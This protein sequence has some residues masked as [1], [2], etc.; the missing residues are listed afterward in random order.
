VKIHLVTPR[1]PPSFW[2]YD[3]ILPTLGKRCIFPNLSMPT[4]AGLTPPEHEVT[5]CDENVR[6][7]DFDVDAD[8]IGITGYIIHAP[9]IRELAREFRR[10]GHRVVIGGPFATLCPERVRELC[11]VLFI[12]E[13]EET[14]PEFLADLERGRFRSEYREAG[15]PDLS[16]AP[17]PRFDLLDVDRYHALTI[18]FG[19]GCPFRCEFCDIIV[20][21]GRRPRTKT[22]EQVLAEIAACH[23]LGANQVFIVDDNF[24]GDRN[25]AKAVLR[26]IA[27]WSEAHGHPIAFNTEVSL[28]VAS[29]PELL[30]LLRRARFT[31]VFVGIESP[32]VASLEE[33]R[34]TQNT[35]GDLLESVRRIQAFGIQVQAGMIVGFDHDDPTIFEEQ[36]RFVQEAAIPVSMT[37]ML[38][39]LPGTPLHQRV[40]R[41]GRLLAESTGDQFVFSNIVPRSMTREELYRGYR[42]LLRR[43]Y[44]YD[45]YRERVAAFLARRGAQVAKGARTTRRELALLLRIL[46]DTVLRADPRRA[47]FTLR[48]LGGTLLRRPAAFRDAVSFAVTHKALYEYMEELVAHLD[49]ALER[50]ELGEARLA[51]ASA[52]AAGA[53]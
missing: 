15:K 10:R 49:H 21:Y 5:L 17:M 44:D 24:I 9:R 52:R 12:G 46:R 6:E 1:N 35:R 42:E 39:A 14:W 26:A 50:G 53:G 19:R 25:R 45:L 13:A 30:E 28:N 48:L 43:L 7:V 16:R 4:V 37:G 22:P 2:T 51:P 47:I 23:R 8:L 11:D 38:Q 36:L 41:E 18:Q 31:T 33:T 34:K 27:G 29:D 40:E 3:R 20:M 32:R